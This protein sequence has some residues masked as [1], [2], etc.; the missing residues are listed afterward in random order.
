[1]T[2]MNGEPLHD[3]LD[4][5]RE[6]VRDLAASHSSFV[7]LNDNANHAS[8]VIETIIEFA[9][10]EVLIFDDV[11][12]GTVSDR[13]PSFLNTL[14]TAAK[15]GKTIHFVMERLLE[16]SSNIEDALRALVRRYPMTVSVRRASQDFVDEVKRVREDLDIEEKIH[17][18]VGDGQSYRLEFPRGARK[19][20]CSFN[21]PVMAGKLSDVFIHWFEDCPEYF[22][23][24]EGVK[25]EE[26][27]ALA[28]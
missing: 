23:S 3:E 6:A 19:A 25:S 26:Q 10:K 22:K 15:A 20:F 4:K 14:R 12:D 11:L 16:G 27:V 8:I 13:S 21:D 9:Q 5:Y 2:K 18:A 7:F 28:T 24:E 1:M 17:F